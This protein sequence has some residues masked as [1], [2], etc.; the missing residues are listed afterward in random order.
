M[1]AR[2]NPAAR[3][4]LAIVA[5]LAWTQLVLALASV[6][7]P[8]RL[9]LAPRIAAGPFYR[10][11]E[12]TLL[13]PLSAAALAVSDAGRPVSV[14][15][16]SFVIALLCALLATG[17]CLALGWLLR[18]GRLSRP[19]G[20]AVIVACVTAVGSAG[21]V[22]GQLHDAEVAERAFFALVSR[23]AVPSADEATVSGAR[24]F[25]RRYP[26]S[27]WRSEALRIVAVHA[28]AHRRFTEAERAWREFE[29]CFDDSSAPGVAYAEYNRAM[30]LE[31]LGRPSQAVACYRAAIGVIRS[32][33]DG[34][35]GWIAPDAATRI[36]RLEDI[37][38]MPVTA[39]YW[40][41][42]SQ[43]LHDVCSIE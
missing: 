21:I 42:Q 28:S 34:V 7:V 16:P 19:L 29:A 40:K 1:R 17:T 9:A 33:S 13:A 20:V 32:R 36:A 24:A 12:W 18:V 10:V 11:A 4:G 39:A 2:F 8:P 26:M 35:Q 25:A 15:R 3:S 37:W 43:T 23:V 38:G 5:G 41:T 30:C 6:V 31:Q 27:R 22:A 14:V